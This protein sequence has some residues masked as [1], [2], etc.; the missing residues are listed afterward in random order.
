[1]DN[2]ELFNIAV[3][4][5]FGR[6]YKSFPVPIGLSVSDIERVLL[7]SMNR[8]IDRDMEVGHKYEVARSSV[9]WLIKSGY[10][11]CKASTSDQFFDVTLTPKGLEILNAIPK[12]LEVN[13]SLGERLAQGVISL[14]KETTLTV[15]KEG[16]S[17]GAR[18][19]FGTSGTC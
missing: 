12:P 4:D 1:M 6:C 15:V 19:L 13:K 10:L 14:G 9:E 16:L 5:T 17:L 18:L 2:I 11:W 8:E 7:Q 3:A